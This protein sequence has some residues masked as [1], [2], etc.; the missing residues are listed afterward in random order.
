VISLKPG[1]SPSSQVLIQVN[2]RPRWIEQDKL[3]QNSP[4]E[5]A[6]RIV[7]PCRAQ[8]KQP[9]VNVFELILRRR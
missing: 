3:R 7:A 6:G 1:V 2:E 8:R 9:T 4:E 5:R